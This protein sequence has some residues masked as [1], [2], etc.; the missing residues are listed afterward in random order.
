M[1]KQVNASVVRCLAMAFILPG[2]PGQF[3]TC[4]LSTVRGALQSASKNCTPNKTKPIIPN[5]SNRKQPKSTRIWVSTPVGAKL[6]TSSSPLRSSYESVVR[7]IGSPG[8]AFAR[9]IVRHVPREHTGRNHMPVDIEFLRRKSER[10]SD[11][12]RKMQDRHI[13]LLPKSF[14]ISR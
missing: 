14:S 1:S 13:E 9:A 8:L 2:S 4:N 3:P 6:S 11:Q 7:P 12:L 10:Q 5:R